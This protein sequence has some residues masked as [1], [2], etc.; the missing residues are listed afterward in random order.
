MLFEL[1]DLTQVITTTLV[2][3]L[4]Q[5]DHE[6]EVIFSLDFYKFGEKYGL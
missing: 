1:D 6:K 3:H 5:K 2:L 4:A